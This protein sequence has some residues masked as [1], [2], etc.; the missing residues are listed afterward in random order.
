[1]RRTAP[2]A[3]HNLVV[4]PRIRDVRW[5]HDASQQETPRHVHARAGQ[6]Q[7]G[8]GCRPRL[9]MK[10]R[11]SASRRPPPVWDTAAPCA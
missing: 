1:V 11:P 7:G 8:R 10:L 2:L 6:T 3:V 9:P 4:V 5:L